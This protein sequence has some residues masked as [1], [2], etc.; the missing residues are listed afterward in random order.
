MNFDR[1]GQ[2]VF[3]HRYEMD[4]SNIK[5]AVN[6][7]ALPKLTSRKSF[8]SRVFVRPRNPVQYCSDNDS[9]EEKY[10]PKKKRI[11]PRWIFDVVNA[12]DSA[13][14]AD[15]TD[16]ANT[17]RIAMNEQNTPDTVNEVCAPNVP[18]EPNISDI[19][20]DA[21]VPNE[22]NDAPRPEHIQLLRT[23]FKHKGFRTRQ[24]EIIR[25][26]MIENRDVVGVMATG[27]GKSLCYQY[28]AVYLNG[29]TLVVCPLIALMQEQVMDLEKK[30]ISACY[31]GS[32][33]SDK[34]MPLRIA[35]GEF[36][37]VY[38][39]PEYLNA[40][41]GKK[42]LHDVKNQ[43]KLIAIDEAHCVSQWGLDFRPHFRRLGEIRDIVPNVPILALTATAT[44]RA[45][46]DIA[47]V[48]NLNRP[49][50]IV[51]GFDRSNLEFAIHPKTEI[52]PNHF[53]YWTDLKPFVE[54][55]DGS[56]IIYVIS[57]AETEN[58][59][60]LLK[61]KNI[62]CE[63]YHA[64][65]PLDKRKETLKKFKSGEIK[66][67]VA[68]IAFGMGIDKRDVRAVIHYGSS[69]TLE[70]YYQEVGRAGRDGQPAKAVT[71][72]STADFDTYDSF[73]Q[74]K[75]LRGDIKIYVTDM[76]SK[77]RAFLYSTRCRR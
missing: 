12:R 40:F 38:A 19:P 6:L 61:Q 63:H 26:L 77:M 66:V 34:S 42:L 22:S 33:Q 17:S 27:Y 47:T 48:L 14:N 75:G 36:R 32:A 49:K 60:A 24:W 25:T 3:H 57:R 39:S 28:P 5:H 46:E 23:V 2:Q 72:F 31:L 65:V 62:I 71:F 4:E 76:Q 16:E 37:L 69:K 70:T 18:F 55:N 58:V 74:K 7:P 67:I 15:A 73:V 50:F 43:I 52:A 30:G 10:S 29:I 11:L 68:T 59:A 8:V 64:Q 13:L 20:I 56:K 53:D 44:E 21:N 54:N 35:S 9:E 1:L 45:R 41:A 51:S